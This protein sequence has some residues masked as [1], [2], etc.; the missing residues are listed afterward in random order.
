MIVYL[1][2]LFSSLLPYVVF[3]CTSYVYNFSYIIFLTFI[4]K[5]GDECLIQ[6]LFQVWH[7]TIFLE[8]FYLE[9]FWHIISNN[10]LSI[11]KYIRRG[12]RVF[13]SFVIYEVGDGFKIR[14]WH[15][16]WCVDLPLNATFPYL[17]SIAHYKEAWVLDN[18]QFINENIL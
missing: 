8:K 18:M 14:F 7:H 6:N 17:F 2:Q 9:L 12:W 10:H 15:D 5:F 3:F 1:T 4:R 13:S 16:L 11:W